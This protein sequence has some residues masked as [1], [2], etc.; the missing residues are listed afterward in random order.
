MSWRRNFADH[1]NSLSQKSADKLA[2]EFSKCYGEAANEI[3]PMFMKVYE[4]ACASVENKRELS[5]TTL[6]NLDAY[7]DLHPTSKNKINDLGHLIISLTNYQFHIMYADVFEGITPGGIAIPCIVPAEKIQEVIDG[8]WGVDKK[9]WKERVWINMTG[10]WDKLTGELMEAVIKRK[11]PKILQANLQK[12][13]EGSRKS[14]NSI[15]MIDVSRIQ[16]KAAAFRYRIS[17]GMAATISADMA[18]Y[19]MTYGDE[20]EVSALSAEDVAAVNTLSDT[21]ENEANANEGIMT[22]GILSSIFDFI[23]DLWDIATGGSGDSD[24]GQLYMWVCEADDLVCEEC[25]EYDGEVITGKEAD[26]IYPLHPNCRCVLEPLE[27]DE[28]DEDGEDDDLGA[29]DFEGGMD[30]GW[31]DMMDD[32]GGFLDSIGAL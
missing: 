28:D 17:R 10:L 7:W 4:E 30:D 3:I 24:D 1:Q 5:P 12:V 27:E 21:V 16:S 29:D 25:A 22:V 20:S 13:F 2:E 9:N 6:F 23:S 31:S 19:V 11:D 26:E 14:L 18:A 32:L 15:I 8:V